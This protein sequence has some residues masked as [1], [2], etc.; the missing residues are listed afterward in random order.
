MKRVYEEAAMYVR[1]IV[2]AIAALIVTLPALLA[3]VD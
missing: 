2:A 1:W 3:S